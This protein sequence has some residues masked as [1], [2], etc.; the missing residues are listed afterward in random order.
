MIIT[1]PNADAS[2]IAMLNAINQKLTK[3]YKIITNP[4]NELL[5]AIKQSDEI[6]KNPSKFKFYTNID[7][8][9][10]ELEND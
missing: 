8:L 1:I 9:F 6:I 4:S 2:L 7:K 3:S 10:D 5:E